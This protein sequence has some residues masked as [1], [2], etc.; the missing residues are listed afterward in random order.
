MNVS[1]QALFRLFAREGMSSIVGSISCCTR[2]GEQPLQAGRLEY[3]EV[4][5]PDH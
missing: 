3:G 1:E 4:K 5:R 2:L